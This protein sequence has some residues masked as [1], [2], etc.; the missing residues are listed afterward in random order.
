MGKENVKKTGEIAFTQGDFVVIAQA[1]DALLH[2][3]SPAYPKRFKSW[4]QKVQG[5]HLDNLTNALLSNTA[6]TIAVGSKPDENGNK[7]STDRLRGRVDGILLMREYI[8][9]YSSETKQEGSDNEGEEEGE[10]ISGDI[11]DLI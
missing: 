7:V 11:T 5:E 9:T 6:F 2:E 3:K 10:P 8:R 4:A 1:V